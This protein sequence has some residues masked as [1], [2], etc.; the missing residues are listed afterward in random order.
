MTL[1][2]TGSGNFL[3]FAV[4]SCNKPHLPQGVFTS[5]LQDNPDVFVWLGD[6][7]YADTMLLPHYW[8]QAHL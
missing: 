1:F 7:V 5:I 2:N 4:G 8:V 6:V 3:R